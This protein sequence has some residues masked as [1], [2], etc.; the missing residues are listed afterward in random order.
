[1]NTVTAMED[2]SPGVAAEFLRQRPPDALCQRLLL[3]CI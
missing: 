1:M 2:V 3:R